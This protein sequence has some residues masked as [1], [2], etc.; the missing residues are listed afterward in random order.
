MGGAETEL[1]ERGC[2]FSFWWCCLWGASNREHG[3]TDF[4]RQ[5]ESQGLESSR[6]EMQDGWVNLHS[7]RRTKSSW[8]F[9]RHR[10]AQQKV[11]EILYIYIYI[12]ITLCQHD[13]LRALGMAFLTL[14]WSQGRDELL[15]KYNSL[16]QPEDQ[17]DNPQEGAK[18]SKLSIVAD[19]SRD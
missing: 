11:Q 3:A 5:H 14:S 17:K 15:W 9:R 19:E 10:T 6:M 18:W 12:H 4:G 2:I 1:E 7:N 16:F 13:N 8:A